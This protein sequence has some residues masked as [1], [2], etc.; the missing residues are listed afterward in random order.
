MHIAGVI[1]E[2]N[3]FHLGHA[4]HLT[5]TRQALGGDTAIVCVMSGNFVQ[6]GEAAIL[7]KWSRAECA[8]RGGADLVLELPTPWAVASAETFA[9]GGVET[10]AATGL[11]DTLSFGCEGQLTDLQAAADCLRT[12]EYHAAMQGDRMRSCSFA[13]ARQKAATTLIGRA[14]DC[15]SLPNNNLAVE[16]LKALAALHC[17]IAPLAVARKGAPHDSA[18]ATDGF[19][20]ASAIRGLLRG[21][22]HA[23]A[24]AL[25][26][27][28]TGEVL[29][30]ELL[31]AH[32]PADLEVARRAVLA[33]LRTMT[34]ADFGALP[35][36]GAAEGL[37]RRMADAA[38]NATALTEFYAAAKTKRYTHARIRRLVLWAFLGLTAEDRPAAIPYLHVLGMN[39]AGKVLLRRMDK[40]CA[41]PVIT[42]P[43]HARKLDDAAQRLFALE[44]RCG[45]LYALCTP[46][47]RPCGLEWT[48]GPV[49]L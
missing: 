28:C 4:Y 31:L 41:L 35:D 42:K 39:A 49:V 33:R 11:V 47:V 40:T 8:L 30:R 19:A 10:L 22:E 38:R 25:M 45:D 37:P 36:S 6:R 13:A 48:S 7:D 1:A 3:P 46:A 15:L 29:A 43:A 12:P 14:A 24:A 32:A 34:E 21:G 9:R 18:A 23:A 27:P 44:A 2:Y 16:Y 5:Q 17:D 26:P 20:S